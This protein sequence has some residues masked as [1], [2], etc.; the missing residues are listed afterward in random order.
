MTDAGPRSGGGYLA[1]LAEERAHGSHAEVVGLKPEI[2]Q[3][4]VTHRLPN[5]ELSG[6]DDGNPHWNARSPGSAGNNQP[7]VA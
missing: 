4:Q 6:C 5:L 2:L 1:E 7:Q 3:R